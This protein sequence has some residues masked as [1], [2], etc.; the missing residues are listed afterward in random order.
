MN[1]RSLYVGAA[2]LICS[3][4]LSAQWPKVREAGVP[5]DAQGR[6]Q[7][8]AAPPRGADGKP[9]LSGV[10]LRADPEPLPPELAGL[11]SQ[12]N[13]DASADVVQEVFAKPF[14]PDP[15]SPPVDIMKPLTSGCLVRMSPTSVVYCAVFGNAVPWAARRLTVRKSMS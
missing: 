10:W 12:A 3:V 11:F 6:V 5:R 9:D 7:I 1:T 2:V 4:S 15:K 13:R 14:P 8:E